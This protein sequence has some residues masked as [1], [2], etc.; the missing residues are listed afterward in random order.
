MQRRKFI[1]STALGAFFLSDI[2]RVVAQN[3]HGK[4]EDPLDNQGFYESTS[5]LATT[6]PIKF[7]GNRKEQMYKQLIELKEK[8][9]I[10]RFLFVGPLEEVRF[11]GFP[12]KNVYAEIGYQIKEAKEKLTSNDIKIGWWCA[13]SLRSG[14]DKR[15]QYITDLDGSVSDT[16]PCP[17]DPIF[18]EEFSN[19]I[20][21]VV[22]IANPYMIQ[23]ED[24]YEL[25]HQPPAVK[26]G[27]FCPLHLN[28]F[29]KRQG[30][31]FTRLELLEKFRTVDAESIR[32]RKDWAA[33]SRDS[34]VSLAKKIRQKVD[35]VNPET[36]ISLCQ[37]GC[38]DFDGDFTKELTE[39][40]AGQTKPTVRL[41]GSSYSSDAPLGLPAELFHA[42]YSIQHLPK[43]F[44]CFH[45]SDT[46]PHSRFFMSASK[47][48]SLMTIAF[49]Y[50]FDQTLFYLTQYLDNL[51]EERG[52]AEMYRKEAA[53]FLALKEASRDS[54]VIGCEIIHLPNASAV[55]P[56]RGGRPEMGLNSWV[57]AMGRFGIPYTTK[58]GKVKM[59]AGTAVMSLSDSEI[60]ALLKGPLVLDGLAAHS[61]CQMG[62]SVY[63][64]VDVQ[65]YKKE[66][67]SC[68]EGLRNKNMYQN[69][70]GDLQYNWIFAP[71]GSEGGRFFE[72]KPNAAVE[73]VT[74]F[75]DE[76]E[77]PIMASMIRYENRLGGRIL[78]SAFDL[79][80]NFSST[81]FNYK[82]KE[83]MR[84]N[85]EWVG[86]EELP[87]F[88]K[89]APNIFCVCSANTAKDTYLITLTNLS[90]DPT[91]NV[92]L[93]IASDLKVKEVLILDYAG[94][95]NRINVQF[96]GRTVQIPISLVLMNPQIIKFKIS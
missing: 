41:Y 42:L 87:V 50:G 43:S 58:G 55:V 18:S 48:K 32:L 70:Q 86:G 63:L 76:H 1:T 38:T 47:I 22:E 36:V 69:I 34:L 54:E 61:L 8:Y 57:N 79:A 45:E 10:A 30:K 19:H 77:N 51:L 17:Y 72:L 85:I 13:P 89:D 9:G 4:K 73:V 39:A 29:S 23:F 7:Y 40:F 11:K 83:L 15:F 67:H 14:F 68:Y 16:S 21:T 84:Q 91:E 49:A 27:C 52:Y 95:W 25:S 46:Y 37:S 78:I 2:Q 71:A 66:I 26:F 93:D 33:L 5:K 74:D 75:L 96:R 80:G 64:G 28:E 12:G 90:S 6:A 60:L 59:L 82:K 88:V 20:A 94:K 56:Y 31:A 35:Q 53:R 62:Y 81:T 44:E 3:Q 65:V 92:L 24:D